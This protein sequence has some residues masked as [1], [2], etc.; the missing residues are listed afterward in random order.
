MSWGDMDENG[1]PISMDK[2][3][4]YQRWVRNVRKYGYNFDFRILNAADYGAYTTRKRFFGIFA[5]NGLPIV[6]PQPTHCKNGKQDM[7]GRLEKW[8]PVK[9]ILDFS[10]EG[11]SIFR[12]KPLAEKTM[13]R[14]YAGLIKFVAGGK[15]AFLIKYNSMSRTGK[16]NAPGIDE[17]CPVVA[18]QNSSVDTPK[19]RMFLLMNQPEQLHAKTI[20]RLYQPITVTDLTAQ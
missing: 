8:R 9:E 14:I 2:G 6:F 12:E 17:P 19:A 16:Y 20:M 7:F 13:E 18:T 5:K 10:D 15:D 1:K 3:R 4:L 11:T